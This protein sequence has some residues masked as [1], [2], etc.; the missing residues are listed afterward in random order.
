MTTN[1]TNSDGVVIK[2]REGKRQWELLTEP[3][4]IVPDRSFQLTVAEALWDAWCK[5][6]WQ[7]ML[8]TIKDEILN[9]GSWFDIGDL[10]V[11][12]LEVGQR[13]G[14]VADSWKLV[15]AEQYIASCSRHLKAHCRG[16]LLDKDGIPSIAGACFAC[17]AL[18]WM[19]SQ[20][21]E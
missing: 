21:G 11:Q 6:D 14:Y 17:Y 18:L 3:Q 10:I 15:P 19:E 2:H 16:E 1:L 4:V 20:Q 12:A 13:K 5:R 8:Y 9:S 7:V